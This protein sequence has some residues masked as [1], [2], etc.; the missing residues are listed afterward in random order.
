VLVTALVVPAGAA[1]DNGGSGVPGNDGG[2][3][4][5][6]GFSDVGVGSVH[7]PA[8]EVL[9]SEGVFEDTEC[10]PGLFCPREPILRWQMAVWLVRVLDGGAG[11]EADVSS[12]FSDVDAGVWWAPY[13]ERLA[14]LGVTRGCATGP[15]RYCP[16]EA[17]TRAQMASFLVRAFD[18]GVGPPAGFADVRPGGTH[19][20]NIDALAAS[21][22]TQGCAETMFCPRR[23]TTRAQM[24]TFLHRARNLGDTAG[25]IPTFDPFTTPTVSDIDLDRLADAIETLDPEVDCPPTVSPASLD[26]VAEV[27]R[28]AD[29]CLNVE[30]IPLEGRTIGEVREELASDPE[31]HAVDLPVTDVYPSDF[32]YDD[33]G[34]E[35]WHLETIEA[36]ILWYGGTSEDGQQVFS[37]WPTEGA[38]VVVAVIDDGV[39]GSHNDLDANLITTGHPCHRKVEL[40]WDRDLN[41]HGTHVAGIIA[42]ERNGRDVVGVAPWARI[43]PIKI[44]YGDDR[45]DKNGNYLGETD[46]DCWELIGSVAAA[47]DMA[48]EDGADV[49]NMSFGG[50]DSETEEAAI[51]AAMMRDIVVV[52]AAGNCGRNTAASLDANACD[53]TH[54]RVVYPAAYPGVISVASTTKDGDKNRRAATSTANRHVGI[55]APG[56]GILST[57]YPYKATGNNALCDEDTTCHV[58]Y[59]SGTSMAA[60]VIS[61]IVVHMKARFPKASVSEIRQALYTTA[62]NPDSGRTGHW[63]PEYGWGIVQPAAAI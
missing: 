33:P 41:D 2:V 31:V 59:R 51:R 25:R 39:L 9:A 58:G 26:D 20:A 36:D 10:G 3:V 12:R 27:V 15:L 43:L 47:V 22:V 62:K 6:G 60:P 4:A 29:G 49:I 40:D 11:P 18:L 48:V 34:K 30:Y 55:A 1:T 57:V 32:H 8:V 23:D 13:V 28:I 52:A 5:V 17:V 38:E 56:S 45:Y 14:E 7:A 19:A 46:P 42:A 63:T 37:G 21:G 24:A 54:N 61:G 44:H 35:Q 16:Q 50:S 53:S